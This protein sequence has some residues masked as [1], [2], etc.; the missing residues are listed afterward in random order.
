[1][2]FGVATTNLYAL[3]DEDND[4]VVPQ[5][6]KA[7]EAKGPAAKPKAAAAAKAPARDAAPAREGGRGG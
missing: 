1:M 4:G 5:V 3:L 6:A 7:A 2:S